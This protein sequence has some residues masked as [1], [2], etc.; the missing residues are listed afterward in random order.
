MKDRRNSLQE[1]PEDPTCGTRDLV[2]ANAQLR[3]DLAM[4]KE[5]EQQVIHLNHEVED[6]QREIIFRLAEIVEAR[7]RETGGHVMRVAELSHLLALKSGLARGEAE[8]LRAAAPMHD[9][10]KVGIP[11][12]ILFN[13]G[14]LSSEEFEVMKTHTT[15]GYK[16]LKGSARPILTHAAVIAL[17]H[18]EKFN[19]TGYP[20]GLTGRQI[21]V[22]GRIVAIADVF[23]ALSS[24]RIYRKAWEMKRIL[25]YL[26][27]QRGECFDPDLLDLFFGHIDDFV[28]VLHTFPTGGGEVTEDVKVAEPASRGCSPLV[29]L[30]RVGNSPDG[31][32]GGSS[33]TSSGTSVSTCPAAGL[34]PGAR[35]AVGGD[36]RDTQSITRILIADDDPVSRTILEATLDTWGYDVSSA[37]RPTRSTWSCGRTNRPSWLSSVAPWAAMPAW[38][39]AAWS[40]AARATMCISSC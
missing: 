5:V 12:A 8:L 10:G 16:M 1:G 29:Q 15:I 11:D 4:L 17:Q 13:P 30:A 3:R 21:H 33:E 20:L 24:D 14:R 36:A 26:E 22:F 39:S 31:T 40:A 25:A 6:T 27:R 23:D 18:H 9:V 37:P 7:S 2:R 35:Q 34:A 38:T 32:S 28:D 19:G